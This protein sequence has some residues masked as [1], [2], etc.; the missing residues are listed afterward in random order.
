VGKSLTGAFEAAVHPT[1]NY[2]KDWPGYRFSRPIN[3]AVV[4]QSSQKTRDIQ[5]FR[6]LGNPNDPSSTGFIPPDLIVSTTRSHGV[7][8]A[9]DQVVVRSVFGGNSTINFR[10][11]D[12]GVRR[13]ASDTFDAVYC[14]E[15]PEK[16]IYE[17]LLARITA[18]RGILYTTFTPTYDVHADAGQHRTS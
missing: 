12:Q 18:T 6:L 8:G 17:E 13:L 4:G 2:P 9:F 3:L 15:E 5:Q 10:S 11:Y 1:G 14:D 16:E 7:Q